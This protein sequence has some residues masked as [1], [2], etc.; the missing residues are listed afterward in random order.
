VSWSKIATLRP[1]KA[2]FSFVAIVMG[3]TMIR[4]GVEHP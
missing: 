2:A 3:V 4:Q 1:N